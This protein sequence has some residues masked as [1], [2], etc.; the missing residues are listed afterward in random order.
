MYTE[1][2]IPVP[3]I[4]VIWPLV[5]FFSIYLRQVYLQALRNLGVDRRINMRFLSIYCQNYVNVI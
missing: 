2:N 4:L 5:Y 3:G 1:K